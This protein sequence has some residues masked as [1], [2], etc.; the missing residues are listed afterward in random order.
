MSDTSPRNQNALTAGYKPKGIPR[1]ARRGDE[2][3]RLE[4]DGE[5]VS[6]ELLDDSGVGA[7]WEVVIRKNDELIVGHRCGTRTAADDAATIFKQDHQR[8]GWSPLPSSA[9]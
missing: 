6:C 4:K 1:T 2:E 9:D 8:T 5:T 7:G 3:W